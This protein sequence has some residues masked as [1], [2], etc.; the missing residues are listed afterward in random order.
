MKIA[1]EALK[2]IPIIEVHSHLDWPTAQLQVPPESL[3][4]LCDSERLT[5]SLL[6]GYDPDSQIEAV[7]RRKER[8]G[9]LMWAR[10]DDERWWKGYEKILLD[11]RD[12]VKGIKIHPAYDGYVAGLETLEELFASA[13]QHDFVIATHTMAEE[14]SNAAFFRPILEKYPQTKLILYHATPLDVALA[15]INDFPNVYMDISAGSF[16][17][18]VMLKALDVVGKEKILFGIDSPLGFPILNGQYQKHFRDVVE[19]EIALWVNYDEKILR[20]VLYLNAT[21]L[22]SLK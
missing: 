4:D 2:N 1:P 12:V 19:K 11:N 9:Y 15:V 17:C 3:M 8:F 18:D 16:G 20:H 21:R 14:T 13:C 6:L 22:F 10:P 7:R 5:Y